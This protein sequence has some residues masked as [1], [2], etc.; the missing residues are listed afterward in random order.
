MSTTSLTCRTSRHC[1]T[2]CGSC[3]SPSWCPEESEDEMSVG[4]GV[5]IDRR[6]RVATPKKPG[7]ASRPRLGALRTG[8]RA[9]LVLI[10]RVAVVLAILGLWQFLSGRV[11]EPF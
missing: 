6:G 2:S 11:I 7:R 5:G 9:Q 10:T 3:W 4:T 8:H 1:G